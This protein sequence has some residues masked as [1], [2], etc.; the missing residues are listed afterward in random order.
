[1]KIKEFKLERYFAKHEFTAKYLLSSSDCDGLPMQQILEMATDAELSLWNNL[2][3]G[4]TE[5]EGSHLLR[6]AILQHYRI[7]DIRQVIVASP[8]ELNFIAMNVLL[9]P[10]EHVITV[11]PGYQSLREVVHSLGCEISFWRPDP[12]NWIFDV[13]DLNEL[14]RK[15]TRLIIINFPHNPTGSYLTRSQM[16]AIIKIAREKNIYL[17]SDEMYR[18]LTISE[19]PELIPACDLYEKGISL[20]GTSKTFGLAGLRLGWLV[21]RDIEF[22][23]KVQS[24]KDY[25]SI[26]NS[27]PSEIL[28][29]IALNHS[30]KIINPILERIKF[31]I[32][33]FQAFADRQHLIERFIPPR[34]GSIGL[35][36]LNI[37]GS[38]AEWSDRL[39]KQTG[40]M[41]VPGE[42]FDYPGK[43]IRIGFGRADFGEALEHLSEYCSS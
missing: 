40:I 10:G 15:N 22:L 7:K 35:V 29:L 2:T 19:M 31:N 17:F 9:E 25:L 38:A 27:A 23:K 3:L 16:D 12:E 6:E 24:F 32:Q 36:K 20:W 4:Y 26:C 18:K 43:Y 41:S 33:I 5:S 37:K 28:T 13:D 34:A 21:C 39:V 14:I 42:M 1:M 8:G 11:S 30:E